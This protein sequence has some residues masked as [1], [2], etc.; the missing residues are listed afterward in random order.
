MAVLMMRIV[1]F[2][3]FLCGIANSM[4]NSAGKVV[5]F[6]RKLGLVGGM[7]LVSWPLT[8]LIAELGFPEVHHKNIITFVEEVVHICACT[9]ICNMMANQESAYRKVSLHEDDNPLGM[10]NYKNR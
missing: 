8:V 3:I 5:I 2:C 10:T 9:F 6:I 7:Y 1:I 4:K